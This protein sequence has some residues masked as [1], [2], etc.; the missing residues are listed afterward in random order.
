[1]IVSNHKELILPIKKK[2]IAVRNSTAGCH[3]KTSLDTYIFHNLYSAANIG[4][5]VAYLGEQPTKNHKQQVSYTKLFVK[6]CS[7]R[8]EKYF[9]SK[10]LH[11]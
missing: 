9:L 4:Q 1:M 5:K 7:L 11:F 2:L 3:F 10:R 8:N 6:G